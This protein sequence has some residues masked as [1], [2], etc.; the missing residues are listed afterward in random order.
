MGQT[1]DQDNDSVATDLQSAHDSNSS[2][3]EKK[4]KCNYPGCHSTFLRPSRLERHM[5]L[6]TGEVTNNKHENDFIM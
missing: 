4:Y 3:E 5:R 2:S 6:H 1:G